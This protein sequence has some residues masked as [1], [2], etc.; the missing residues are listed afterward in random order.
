VPILATVGV[1]LMALSVWQRRGILRWIGLV[2]F[3]LLCGFEWFTLVVGTKTPNYDGP[4]RRDHQV[5]AFAT[6][7]AD[8]KSF[9]DN[10]L[11][12]GIPTVLVFFRGRW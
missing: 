11:Q 9:T 5:P 8:G 4:A 12:K 10:D 2:L 1:L 6:T 3:V 7:L